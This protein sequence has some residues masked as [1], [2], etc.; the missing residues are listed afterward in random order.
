MLCVAVSG[1][2]CFVRPFIFIII[3]EPTGSA[4]LL[5]V[6]V[7]WRPRATGACCRRVGAV[8]L[9]LD[10]RRNMHAGVQ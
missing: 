9:I 6:D 2:R 7:L 10:V 8:W 1:R 5:V 3:M 4:L